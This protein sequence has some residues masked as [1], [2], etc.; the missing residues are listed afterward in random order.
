MEKYD[1]IKYQKRRKEKKCKICG[2]LF[3]GTDRMVSCSKEC[4][5]KSKLDGM[6]KHYV[7]KFCKDCGVEIERRVKYGKK[8]KD[9]VL[10]NK[11]C[12]PCSIK[13]R[14]EYFDNVKKN[15][16]KKTEEEKAIKRA[17]SSERMK[18]NNPMF[19]PG[20]IKRVRATIN[21]KIEKGEIKYKTG[22]EHHLWKGNRDNN[23]I[24]RTRLKDWRKFLL[25]ESDYKCSLC[26]GNKK[27]E[28][29]HVEPLR[30]IVDKFTDRHLSEYSNESEEFENLIKIIVEYHFN[31]KGVGICVCEKCHSEI[32]EYRRQ[33]IK[34]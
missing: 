16:I 30:E 23:H 9:K 21:K 5:R 13:H 6:E 15:R 10:K 20:T 18:K 8:A 19:N 24:I 34:K 1:P 14:K 33:T 25:K 22:K 3:L 12:K 29:H 17:E 4:T 2:R 31:K 7:V 26:S 27:L 28:I 11:R 32:D